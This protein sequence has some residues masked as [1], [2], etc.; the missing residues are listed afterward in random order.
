M[1]I[2][3][4]AGEVSGD[5]HGAGVVRGLKRLYPEADIFGVGGDRMKA[6]HME[7]VFHIRE[8]S[9]MGFWEVVKHLP[10]IRVV[11]KTLEALL[12]YRRPDVLLLI[13]YPG[14][15]LRFA[16]VAKR[17]GIKIVYYISPQVWAWNPGRVRKM[18]GIIDEMVVVFP[19]EVP[20]YEKE[21][22][23]VTF[24]GHPLLETLEEP[25]S[26]TQFRTRYGL[27]EDKP[28]VGLFPGSRKQE[29]ER[30]FPAMLGAARM[31]NAKYGAQIVVGAASALDAEFV[32]SFLRNN[33]PVQVLFHATHDVMKNA[34]VAVVTSGTAT[35]ETGLFQTP[36]VVVYKTSW[37]T[38]SIGRMLIRIKN[39]ALVNIVA[40]E[41]VVTELI[42]GKVTPQNIFKF[43]GDLLDNEPRRKDISAR[44][45]IVRQRLGEPG[46]AERTAAIVA[47]VAARN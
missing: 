13:D 10:A 36:M 21:H 42:Q 45:A 8:L 2:M 43:V 7:L 20:Y 35:L 23:P 16:K 26:A 27:R 32:K 14:F 28:V 22:V 46:A 37:I 44:L 33:F 4:I 29:I 6:E 19:F 31:L 11:R 5:M 30:I 17:D 3:I 34:A 9:V 25:Q 18:R 40:G 15:N 1:R 41:T 38:Y 24:V 12:K 39:I 47:R